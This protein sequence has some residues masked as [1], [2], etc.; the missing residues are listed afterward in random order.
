MKRKSLEISG[1]GSERGLTSDRESRKRSV[2]VGT[3]FKFGH[4]KEKEERQSRNL[5]QIR[6]Q[7][8]KKSKLESE[9][10][11]TSDTERR[12]EPVRVG[13]QLHQQ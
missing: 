3:W 9:P 6:T 2:R 8:A 1:D 10:E 13:T 7:K 11:P 12:K 5:V 4:R